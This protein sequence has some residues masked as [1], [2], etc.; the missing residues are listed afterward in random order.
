M[1]EGIHKPIRPVRVRLDGMRRLERLGKVRDGILIVGGTLYVLGY[2]VWSVH[3][4]NEG[5]GL[6]PALELQYLLAGSLLALIVFAAL[7]VGLLIVALTAAAERWQRESR[8][9]WLR[10]AGGS[11]PYAIGAAVSLVTTGLL[12]LAGVNPLIAFLFPGACGFGAVVTSRW[13]QRDEARAIMILT[14]GMIAIAGAVFY[15][16]IAYPNVPQEIGGVKP[17]CGYLDVARADASRLVAQG[18]FAP[19]TT[20]V[21]ARSRK[22]SIFFAG[23]D[24]YVV[25]VRDAEGARTYDVRK[26]VVKT[27][28]YC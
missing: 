11:I 1:T 12:I 20:G 19:H 3:A 7:L 13:T 24:A 8:R 21:V 26:D 10:Q 5:L 15:V 18:L 23:G 28:S 17:R 4:L 14:S 9:P 22:L 2:V 6:L 27:V 16:T 25:R